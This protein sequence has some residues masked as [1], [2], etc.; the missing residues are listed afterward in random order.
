VALIEQPSFS[1]EAPAQPFRIGERVSAAASP[2]LLGACHT[3][4][5]KSG[6][7]QCDPTFVSAHDWPAF[8]V[9][10]T[11]WPVHSVLR[12]LDGCRRRT[13]EA[14]LRNSE[15]HGLESQ[16]RG[17]GFRHFGTSGSRFQ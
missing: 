16:G 2:G 10:G 14:P 13:M 7:W 11:P 3:P 9:S 12:W 4:S 15:F 17:L 8:C 6:V 1:L 5:G